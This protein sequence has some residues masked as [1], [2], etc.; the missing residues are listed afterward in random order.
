MNPRCPFERGEY[1][2]PGDTSPEGCGLLPSNKPAWDFYR[3]WKVLGAPAFEL[4][5]LEFDDRS[6]AE[7]FSDKLVMIEKYIPILQ[8]RLRKQSEI[9]SK[10]K[11]RRN[12]NTN[13]NR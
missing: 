3:K 10:R 8:D 6:E 5:Q 11:G 7:L 2:S 12:G 1:G 13:S 4:I 9:K